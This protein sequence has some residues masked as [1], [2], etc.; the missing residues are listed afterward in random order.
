MI[1]FHPYFI[2]KTTLK[3][4]VSWEMVA[5]SK[6]RSQLRFTKWAVF[7]PLIQLQ[8]IFTALFA[9]IDK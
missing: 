9:T 5:G 6:S 3:Y 1:L 4:Q 7:H 8:K 2:L